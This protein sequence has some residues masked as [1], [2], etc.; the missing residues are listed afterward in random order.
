MECNMKKHKKGKE[1][2]VALTKKVV[3]EIVIPKMRKQTREHFS[4]KM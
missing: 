2:E 1:L 3:E 4:V